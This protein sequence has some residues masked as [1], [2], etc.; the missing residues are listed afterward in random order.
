MALYDDDVV[1]NHILGADMGLSITVP[2]GQIA[3]EHNAANLDK[4]NLHAE[5]DM[6]FSS[7]VHSKEGSDNQAPF[8][9][10]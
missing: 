7:K 10:R 9:N 8:F 5:F 6:G 1:E 3:H 4:R 2:K